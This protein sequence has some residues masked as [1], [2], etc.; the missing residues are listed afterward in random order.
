M[1]KQESVSA[2]STRNP[3]SNLFIKK[4]SL[5]DQFIVWFRNFLDNGE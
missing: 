5:L 2:F 4:E 3:E 1:R